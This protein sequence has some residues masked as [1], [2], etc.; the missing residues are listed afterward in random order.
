[1]IPIEV[2]TELS[3]FSHQKQQLDSIE[4]IS[5]LET[6]NQEFV[7]RLLPRL[8][9]GEAEAIVLALEQKAD[10]IIMDEQKGRLVARE[11]GLTIIGVLGVLMLAKS[12]GYISAVRPVLDELIFKAGFRIS[13]KL[14]ENICMQVGEDTGS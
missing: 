5:I 13:Q 3:S 11:Y 2:Y 9:K 4:W 14:Y 1:L 7:N 8:D 12:E 10:Y 6:G